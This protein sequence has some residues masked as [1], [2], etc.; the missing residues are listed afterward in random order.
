MKK[1]L[2][3]A[4]LLLSCLWLGALNAAEVSVLSIHFPPFS[5]KED[6][7]FIG[8]CTDVIQTILKK[9]NVA[10]TFQNVP[11]VRATQITKS[12]P[13][14]IV[15]PVTIMQEYTKDILFVGPIVEEDWVLFTTDSGDVNIK[16]EKEVT[17]LKVGALRGSEFGAYLKTLGAAVEEIAEDGNNAKKLKERRIQAWGTGSLVGPYLAYMED[18]GKI[19]E[20]FR[21]KKAQL[22]FGISK[23]TEPD[24][25]AKIQQAFEEL[26]NDGSLLKMQDEYAKRF[27]LFMSNT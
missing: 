19:K 23:T 6:N 15:Y 1:S 4:V 5:M 10:S 14:V 27:A 26:K 8:L 12:Q 9:A 22:F 16:S 21:W 7:E 24:A 11:L 25:L 3:V 2:K 13:N 17:G 18:I 20:L